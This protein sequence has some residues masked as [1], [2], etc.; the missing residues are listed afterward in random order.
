MTDGLHCEVVPFDQID[1][2]D[3]IFDSVRHDYPDHDEWYCRANETKD[4]RCALVVRASL[5]AYAGIAILKYGES[6]DGPSQTGLKISTFKVAP[7][8]QAQGIADILLSHVFERAIEQQIDVVFTTVLPNHEDVSRYLELRGF[9]RVAFETRRGERIYVADISHPERIYSDLNRL[10][11]D[12]LADEYRNRSYSPGPTQ[13]SP[14]YLAG[15]LAKH[16]L[17]SSRRVLE[18]G[19]GSGEVLNALGKVAVDTVSVEISPRMA[20]IARQ[21]APNA[22]ILI[23]DILNLDF[24]PGSFDGVY[25]GAFLHL[26]PQSEAARLVRQ[27]ARWTRSDGAVFVNT[28]IA[29]EFSE[30][31]ELKADYLHRV[32]RFRSRWTEDQFQRLVKSNGLSIIERVTTDERER[33]K[34]WVAYLCKPSMQN[35]EIE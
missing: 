31:L 33:G 13:E 19:P 18:L 21:R 11:Y 27:I 22:L 1:F 5:S 15:L 20:M 28:S 16:L 6:P 2:S 29:D 14:E 9:R 4:S 26:F 7:Q 25:A 34:F 30:S 17:P 23:G 24:P 10:A 8:A 32:A 35:Q 3:P 12:L